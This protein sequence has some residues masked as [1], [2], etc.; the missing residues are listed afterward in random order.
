ML[1]D[2]V[3]E[4]ASVVFEVTVVHLTNINES[5]GEEVVLLMSSL[6]E[7]EM[8]AHGGRVEVVFLAPLVWSMSLSSNQE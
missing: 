1:D 6:E 4:T 8:V 2:G 5:I 7:A 3:G